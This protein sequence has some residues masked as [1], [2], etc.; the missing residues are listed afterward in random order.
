M[1]AIDPK[2]RHFICALAL[3]P[4]AMAVAQTPPAPR[5]LVAG[6]VRKLDLRAGT[7]TLRHERIPNLDMDAMTMVFKARPP[8]LLDGLKP[9]DK[10]RFAAD[11][12]GG[13]LVVTA[14]ER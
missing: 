5:P 12:A 9:G 11:M 13:E 6:E 10:V 8:A 2:K 1:R 3:L 7:V 4:A 14:I